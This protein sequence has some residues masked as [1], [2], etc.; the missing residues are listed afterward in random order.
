MDVF[1]DD[2]TVDTLTVKY[3]PVQPEECDTVFMPFHLITA[4]PPECSG[5]GCAPLEALRDMVVEI[6]RMR[7]HF[8]DHGTIE[9]LTQRV[10]GPTPPRRKDYLTPEWGG[11]LDTVTL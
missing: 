2:T 3:F 4:V 10:D 1:I 8:T 6:S 5:F 11:P 9:L 7:E